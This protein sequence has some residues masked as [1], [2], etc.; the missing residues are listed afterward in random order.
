MWRVLRE[1]TRHALRTAPDRSTLFLWRV[2]RA[3]I[4]TPSTR[5]ARISVRR[6]VSG[7]GFDVRPDGRTGHDPFR[8]AGSG[9]IV[10]A[11]RR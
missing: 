4:H 9:E 3:R 2:W 10:S 7:G 6:M 8:A 1:P 5:A 11:L